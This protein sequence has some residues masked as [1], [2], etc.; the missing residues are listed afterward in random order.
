MNTQ[1]ILTVIGLI[2]SATLTLQIWVLK[3]LSDTCERLTKVETEND[4]Y[5][6]QDKK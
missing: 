5:H 1:E 6:D 4:I 3:K 2:S